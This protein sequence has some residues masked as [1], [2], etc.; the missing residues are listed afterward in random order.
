[1][2]STPGRVR[3]FVLP[4]PL[5][6]LVDRLVA[7]QQVDQFVEQRHIR[8]GPGVAVGAPQRLVGACG[9]QPFR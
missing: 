5:G 4:F 1:M 7:A 2:S 3:G 8:D 9:A 6:G